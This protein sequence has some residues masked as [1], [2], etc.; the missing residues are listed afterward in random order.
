[1]IK[2]KPFEVVGREDPDDPGAFKLRAGV[3]CLALSIGW[4][5]AVMLSAVALLVRV[6]S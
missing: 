3:G 5:V 4:L 6:F 1:M 2:V